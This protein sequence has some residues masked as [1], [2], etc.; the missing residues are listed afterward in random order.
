MKS[1]EFLRLLCIIENVET[2]LLPILNCPP[3]HLHSSLLKHHT[4]L[5]TVHASSLTL[6]TSTFSPTALRKSFSSPVQHTIHIIS[7][8]SLPYPPLPIL[9]SLL[10]YGV[11]SDGGGTSTSG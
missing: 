7:H 9:Y 2:L 6:F 4:T 1:T 3:L 11:D 5:T 10:L 8:S